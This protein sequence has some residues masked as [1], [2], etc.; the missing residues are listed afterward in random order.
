M[1]MLDETTL[2]SDLCACVSLAHLAIMDQ[3]GFAGL[4]LLKIVIDK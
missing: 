2:A 1:N 4:M 3:A